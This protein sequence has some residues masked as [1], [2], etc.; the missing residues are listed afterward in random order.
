MISR[1]GR[2]IGPKNSRIELRVARRRVLEG[3]LRGDPA[4]PGRGPPR[5]SAGACPT[6][7]AT[8]RRRRP[9]ARE[10]RRPRRRRRA[11]RPGA[12]ARP[13][14]RR[15]APCR[16][17]SA[18]ATPPMTR[19]DGPGGEP[20]RDAERRPGAPSPRPSA[21]PS[22]RASAA[23]CAARQREERHARRLHEAGHRERR[24]QAEAAD[25]EERPPTRATSESA[26]S[27]PAPIRPWNVS[28]SLAK[29][30][31]GGRPL[32]AAA[33]IPNAS[34]VT[35]IARARP[36]RTVEVARPGRGLDRARGEEQDAT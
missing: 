32:I 28:H 23:P 7:Q 16:P 15:S 13:A 11:R 9:A 30:L 17:T 26:P 35:G 25:G 22:P 21:G 31:S 29:P 8:R 18:A 12:A 19:R 4:R 14:M 2:R 36:P 5:P 20:D 1:A 33:P 6:S 24:G 10:R 34:A 27:P 3:R